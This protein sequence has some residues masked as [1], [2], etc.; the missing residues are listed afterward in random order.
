MGLRGSKE[1]V[2]LTI[3]CSQWSLECPMHSHW[4]LGE[5]FNFRA[6]EKDQLWKIKTSFFFT[7]E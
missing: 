4:P 6:W 2:N 1:R 5:L 3:A 7:S